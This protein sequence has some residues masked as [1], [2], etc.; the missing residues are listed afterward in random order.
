[1]V[2]FGEGVI[3]KAGMRLGDVVIGEAGMRLGGAFDLVDADV[4]VVEGDVARGR[5]LLPEF[6]TGL[7]MLV[8]MGGTGRSVM[9]VVGTAT[10]SDGVEVDVG[11][12]AGVREGDV[13]NDH[14]LND[15]VDSPETTDV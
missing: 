1:M 4:D 11:V 15:I 12:D 9:S 10:W 14:S 6:V 3:G 7:L 5:I 8:L 2:T 13:I